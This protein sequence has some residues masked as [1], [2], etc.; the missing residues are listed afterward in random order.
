MNYKLFLISLI[1]LMSVVFSA[2]VII[3]S[4]NSGEYYSHDINILFNISDYNYVSNVQIDLK[5]IDG[6]DYDIINTK[7]FDD[8]NISDGS[9]VVCNDYNFLSSQ[10]CFY[11]WTGNLVNSKFVVDGNYR[12]LVGLQGSSI[13]S[14][15]VNGIIIDNTSPSITYLADG[16]YFNPL[17]NNLS[18]SLKDNLSGINVSSINFNYDSNDYNYQSQRL[19]INDLNLL[20]V[21]LDINLLDLNSFIEGQDYNFVLDVNDRAGNSFQKLLNLKVDTNAPV[22]HSVLI[23]N[24]AEDVY[25]RIDINAY[26]LGSGISKMQFSCDQNNWSNLVDFN[27]TYNGFDITSSQAGCSFTDGD[28]NIYVRVRDYANNFSNIDYNQTVLYRRPLDFNLNLE[29]GVRDVNILLNWTSARRGSEDLNYKVY[30]YDINLVNFYL[31]ADLNRDVNN[32]LDDSNSNSIDSTY[33]YFIQAVNQ[34]GRDTNTS[35]KCTI[36][37][38]NS[39]IISNFSAT[40]INNNDVLLSVTANDGNGSGIK[41]YYFS[42]NNSTWILTSDSNYTFTNQSNGNKTYYV[43]VSDY[44]DNNSDINQVLI[45][46][47]YTPPQSSSGGSS[48]GRYIITRPLETDSNLLVDEEIIEE[49]A[50]DQPEDFNYSPVVWPEIPVVIEDSNELIEDEAPSGAGFFGLLGDFSWIA[51]LLI[52]LVGLIII[53]FKSKKRSNVPVFGIKKKWEFKK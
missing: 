5:N 20:N 47:D 16:N 50:I 14:D 29:K 9:G 32:Y 10:L 38:Q 3:I 18:F 45:T 8:D 44:A 53:L 13:Q 21:S 35:V 42:D 25:P 17:D 7:I 40:I 22:I 51:I 46:V 12:I 11:T 48:G 19:F 34:Y 30:K 31:I 26:D 37:D 1:F 6:T 15:F 49:P 52:L 33:C 24:P 23:E 36:V 43:F 28:K 27:S 4:P 41:R 39:P 2:S